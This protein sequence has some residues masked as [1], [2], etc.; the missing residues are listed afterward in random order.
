LILTCTGVSFAHGS[1]DGQKGMGLIMIMLIL[2][3]AVPTAYAL[4]HTLPTNATPA[5]PQAMEQG[6]QIFDRRAC[7]LV[8]TSKEARPA[9]EEAIRTRD[10][11]RPL[12]YACMA[13]LTQDIADQVGQYDAIAKVPAAS[14]QNVRND[15]YLVSEAVR[16]IQLRGWPAT[17]PRLCHPTRRRSTPARSSSR[18]G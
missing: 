1:N 14:V 9:V 10:V 15:M 2:I 6:R 7:N 8:M 18:S 16:L 3:G 13:R 5:F 17:M 4:N 12:V 11:D